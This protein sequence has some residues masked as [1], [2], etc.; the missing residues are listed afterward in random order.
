MASKGNGAQLQA[1]PG[2]G[3]PVETTGLEPFGK[4]NCPACGFQLRVERVFENYVVTEP[5]GTGGMGSV[6]KARDTRL[7][8]FVA[9]KLLRKEFAGDAA[10][11]SKLK[12]EARITASIKH[13]HVVE[14]YAVGED[15]GQFYV[16]MELVD[17]GSLD[18]RIE[19]EKRI[20][21]REMLEV[22]LQVAKG[23]QAALEAGLIHRDIKPGNILFSDRSAAKIVDFGLALFAAQHAETEG[24]IWGTPYYVAPERLTNSKEDF[25]SDLYSLGATL[26]HAVAGRPTF[27][28]E[29]QS[30]AELN[31]LKANPVGLKEVARH[32]SEESALVI[33]KM[34]RPSPADRQG[35]YQEL[36]VKLESAHAVVL[37]REEELRGRWSWPK[38]IAV[39]L[40]G[41]LLLAALGFG[42]SAGLHRLPRPESAAEVAV[43]A[44]AAAE[45]NLQLQLAPARRELQAGHYASAEPLFSELALTEPTAQPA[46]ELCAALQ[47]W[48]RGQF[49]QAATSLQRFVDFKPSPQFDWLNEYKPLAR[50]RL[51]DYQLYRAWEKERGSVA[52]PESA[53]ARTRAVVKKL[54][55][56]GALAFQMADE[57]AKLAAQAT[58]AAE[59]RAAEE[60]KAAA[61]ETPRWQA[62]VAAERQAIAAYRF[63][64]AREI[65]ETAK[66]SAPSLLAER[67]EEL[68][69]ARW[70][71]DWKTKLISDINGTGFGGVV[72]DIHNVRY[73]GPIRR[74]TPDKIE[75]KTRYGSVMTS[76]LNLSPQTLLT[77]STAF[78]RPQ[79]EDL[80]ERQWLSAVFALQ[81]GQ[82]EKANEL[83]RAAAEAKPEFRA[84]LPRFFPTAKK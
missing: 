80:A 56:K 39:S 69:R 72:T 41:L 78:I 68:Q 11:T 26:F 29:T 83:A 84:L 6:Y 50:E 2:C 25:R 4:M 32:V 44:K 21:E 76:W 23:L 43:K 46:A 63:E 13:P 19:D 62:A 40:G 7:N 30:A 51:D 31:R 59:K 34:L 24:E 57:E 75:L 70:L 3:Q 8:R 12:E 79:V 17:G 10:F 64:K 35:S 77:M 38:R 58:E 67:E 65:I 49:A 53:L 9:L 61:E 22:G 20:S 42:I 73:D 14:V 33:D 47:L 1:C 55:A 52:D 36:I 16:V 60:K 15:Q 5:L 71:A 48:E 28:D 66:L 45:Q 54:K 27:E 37:A 18:D 74:A 81:T 82:T